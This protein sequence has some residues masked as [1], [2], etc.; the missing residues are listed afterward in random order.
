MVLGTLASLAVALT[1]NASVQPLP[2]PLRAELTGPSWHTGCP[3]GLSQL[4]LLTVTHW[5]L[6]RRRHVGQLV[7]NEAAAAPLK[8][9]FRRLYELRFPIRDMRLTS[10]YGAAA[11]GAADVSSAFE[12]RL[13]VP[14]PCTGASG[15]GNWSQHAY[16][17]AIDINPTENPYVGCGQTRQR[18]SLPYLDRT[19]HRRG[20]VTR[21]AVRAF[22]SIGWGWGGSW[23]GRDKDYMHFSASGH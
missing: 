20:M 6:D 8:R 9:V 18:A 22:A 21:S 10:A 3:V 13:A 15:T 1:F 16:G 12:C 5:G 17:L 11:A 7:V 19:T 2:A 4:R 14:S 23:A